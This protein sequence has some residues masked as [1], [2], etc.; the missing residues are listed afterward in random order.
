MTQEFAIA[1]AAQHSNSHKNI[2]NSQTKQTASTNSVD[3][4]H[5]NKKIQ[6]KSSRTL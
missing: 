4:Q 6:K 5:V 1:S 3:L 2:K